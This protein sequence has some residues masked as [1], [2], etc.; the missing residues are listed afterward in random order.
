M[1]MHQARYFIALAKSLN[2]TRAAEQC[3]VTQPALTKA[4]QKLEQ[5]LDGALI[6]RERRLT[7]L[8]DLGKLV[9]PMVECTVAA[10][11]SVR[12]HAREFQRKGIAPLKIALEP[13]VS[14][15]VLVE[16]LAELA[17]VIP[18]L[19]VELVEAPPDRLTALLLEG[20]ASAV[21][22]G[23]VDE[24][25]DRIDCWRLFEERFVVLA[26]IGSRISRW[27]AV[28]MHALTDAVWL[29][30]VGCEIWRRFWSDY[31]PQ[32]REPKV[33]HRGQQDSQ[34]QHMVAA[35]LGV[36]LAPEHAP[37]LPSLVARPIAGDRLRRQVR[38]L[39]VAGRRYS[40]ALDAFVKTCRLR[41]WQSACRTQSCTRPTT[42]ASPDVVTERGPSVPELAELVQ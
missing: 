23:S 10:A 2:F 1:E 25:L 11:D 39:V 41:D 31:V 24:S 9:L 35:G 20:E 4:L 7:Q 26:A 8:T 27:D 3:N 33:A 28:P 37:H 32:T 30:R 40:P 19:Q 38:L 29:A 15:T 22:S 6:H 12:V 13:S 36:M 5:E 18:G 16:P 14:A 34:L 42:E 17:R 21:I